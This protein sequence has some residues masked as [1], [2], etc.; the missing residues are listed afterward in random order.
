MTHSDAKTI[1]SA[2]SAE[3]L[4]RHLDFF[5]GVRRDTGGPGEDKVVQYILDT[6]RQDGIET[7]LHE[8]DA[9]LSYPRHARLQTVDGEAME[10]R[11]LTH[12]FAASTG[13]QGRI[14]EAVVVPP[15]GDIR[16]AAGRF[17]LIDGLASPIKVLEASR[18]GCAGVIFANA[19]WYIHNMVT[20]TIWGGAPTP[21]L[22]DRIPSVPVVSVNHES[23]EA[24]KER[25]KNGPVRLKMTTTVE[26]GWFRSKMPEAI[27]RPAKAI[28]DA[29]VLT[30]GHYCSWEV[31]V[32]DNSTG[33][34]DILELARVFH[35]HRDHIGRE[36]RF[37]WWPGHSHG[38]YAGSTYYADT[39]FDDLSKRCIAYHNID[40][41]GVKGASTYIVRHTTADMEDIG[42]QI[43]EAFTPQKSPEAHRPNRSADQ[44]FVCLGVPAVAIYSFIP[45]GHPD[46]KPWTGGCAGAW[47]WHTEHDTRDKAD[48]DVLVTDTRASVGLLHELSTTGTLP[49]RP[50]KTLAEIVA[51]LDQIDGVPD[52]S[53]RVKRL[54]ETAGRLRPR[55]EALEAKNEGSA[56]VLADRNRRLL[57]ATRQLNTLVYA[58]RDR[59]SHDAA[60]LT[61]LMRAK[62][63]TMVPGLAAA[64]RVDSLTDANERGF[65]TAQLRRQVNRFQDTLERAIAEVS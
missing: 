35:A 6:L 19:E 12:S 61:P 37:A 48:T 54:L 42:A 27:V 16:H 38:R 40:S 21:D 9:F 58:S 62:G 5:A 1:A 59:F 44:S 29:F 63:A 20:T 25:L 45:Q 33:C 4:D 30:G 56:E 49:L 43:I 50:S 7:R 64:T 55:L 47:W 53:I 11:C 60:D 57:A 32:T 24:I 52:G 41:P 28:D 14:A 34:S 23:G 36:L 46:R 18:A 15:D 10:F 39:Q 2:V 8:F 51:V 22:V 26:T 65:L 17:A 3:R 13:G 31:G